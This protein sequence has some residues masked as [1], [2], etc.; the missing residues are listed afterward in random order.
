MSMVC[1]LASE[2]HLF[3]SKTRIE[4]ARLEFRFACAVIRF[5]LLVFFLFLAK[6]RPR[7]SR[8]VH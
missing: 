7:C 5:A 8:S 4:T 2:I 6:S 1:F 3:C